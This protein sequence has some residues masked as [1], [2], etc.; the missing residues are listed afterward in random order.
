METQ[1]FAIM[2]DLKGHIFEKNDLS[3]KIGNMI[4]KND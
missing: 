4:E 3:I 2:S 1:N